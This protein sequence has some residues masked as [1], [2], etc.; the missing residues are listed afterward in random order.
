MVSLRQSLWAWDTLQRA[1]VVRLHVGWLAL[2]SFLFWTCFGSDMALLTDH[3]EEKST[4]IDRACIAY[5][6]C[7]A[8]DDATEFQ[9]KPPP[10]TCSELEHALLKEQQRSTPSPLCV[11]NEFCNQTSP[12]QRAL[13]NGHFQLPPT[14]QRLWIDLGADST[15]FTSRCTWPHLTWHT[16]RLTCKEFIDFHNIT[17]ISVDANTEYYSQLLAIDRVLPISAAIGLRNSIVVFNH[18]AGPGCSSLHNP[19]ENSSAPDLCKHVLHREVVP[20]ITMELILDLIPTTLNVEFLK[21]DLQGEDL[22]AAKSLGKHLNR[23]SKIYIEVQEDEFIPI[24]Y[25]QPKMTE[26]KGWFAGHGCAYNAQQSAL[27]NPVVGEWNLMF[28]C[29]PN[30]F[31][32]QGNHSHMG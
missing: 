4:F 24:T 28:D 19:T 14:T 11:S 21:I 5:W 32:A 12:L 30:I 3:G 6:L 2:L 27:E 9:R 23:V 18:Y 15:T 7:S 1:V 10:G 8:C 29:N 17:A 26:V 31:L 25:G 22:N 20:M 16:G 13:K